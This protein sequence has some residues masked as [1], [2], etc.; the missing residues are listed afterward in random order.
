MPRL[1]LA[2]LLLSGCADVK[3]IGQAIDSVCIIGKLSAS[4]AL[5]LN[6]QHQKWTSPKAKEGDRVLNSDCSDL[7]KS[8]TQGQ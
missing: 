5:Y 3:A 7:S 6:A 1:I 4:D 2:V 8:V